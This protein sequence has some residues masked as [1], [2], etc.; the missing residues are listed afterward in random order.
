MNDQTDDDAFEPELDG[1]PT[2]LDPRR[3]RSR[4]QIE[5]LVS[6]YAEKARQGQTPSIES[7]V[8]RYPEMATEIREL[9]PM[10]AALEQWKSDRESEVL[11]A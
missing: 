9:F 5:V 8:E 3:V 1:F 6:E 4:V 7:Y 2:D 10:V 11:R